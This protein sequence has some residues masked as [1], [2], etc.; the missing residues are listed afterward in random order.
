MCVRFPLVRKEEVCS[1]GMGSWCKRGRVEERALLSA[2][3]WLEAVPTES[4][5]G[6]VDAGKRFARRR[7]AMGASSLAIMRWGERDQFRDVALQAP[8]VR[9]QELL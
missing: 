2:S 5:G 1:G 9:G 8:F 4:W 7:T 6:N 3:V